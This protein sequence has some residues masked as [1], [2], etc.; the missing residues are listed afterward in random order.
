MDRRIDLTVL[1]LGGGRRNCI[2]MFIREARYALLAAVVAGFGRVFGEVGVSMML[3]GNIKGYTRN[4]TTAIALETG[5]GDLALGFAL[6]FVLLAIALVI[7]IALSILK[8]R[9]K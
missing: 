8:E 5:R 4:I 6:G 7:N 2:S 9:A 1:S 3:G